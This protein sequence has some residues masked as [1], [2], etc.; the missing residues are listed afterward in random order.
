MGEVANV[1]LIAPVTYGGL[2][3]QGFYGLANQ[4]G[5]ESKRRCGTDPTQPTRC[6]MCRQPV[7]EVKAPLFTAPAYVAMYTRLLA[8]MPAHTLV[9]PEQI[10]M[11]WCNLI[12]E[13]L[14]DCEVDVVRRLPH[15]QPNCI[16]RISC[17][18]SYATPLEHL[19]DQEIA[20]RGVRADPTPP[21]A[22]TRI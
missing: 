10:D 3:N 14:D 20:R 11:Y 13:E 22:P 9:T 7:V 15:G 17:A 18:I 8:R 12:G 21:R 6:M 4:V 16:G 5:P 1:S 19:D 2:A